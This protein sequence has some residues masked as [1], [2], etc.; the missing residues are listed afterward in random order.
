MY[1]MYTS[2]RG[3]DIVKK[4]S[5]ARTQ[6]ISSRRSNMP[7]LPINFSAY[8]DVKKTLLKNIC[9]NVG[10]NGGAKQWKDI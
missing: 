2:G 7:I 9:P 3:G 4:S 1:K 10:D 6:G 8:G 5:I